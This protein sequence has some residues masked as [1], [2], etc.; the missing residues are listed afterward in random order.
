MFI[1]VNGQRHPLPGPQTLQSYV[2]YSYL[3]RAPWFVA[4]G[5]PKNA[6]LSMVYAG[7]RY[8]LPSTAGTLLRVPPGLVRFEP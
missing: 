4:P 6:H 3:T 8:I 7:F 2:Q 5:T 1:V